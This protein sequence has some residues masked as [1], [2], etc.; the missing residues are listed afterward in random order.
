METWISALASVIQYGLFKFVHA[1]TFILLRFFFFANYR[2]WFNDQKNAKENINWRYTDKPSYQI[3]GQ[4]PFRK[5][6]SRQLSPET[7]LS[8]YWI[9]NKI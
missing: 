2:D 7:L 6:S 3:H 5:L 1:I 9:N 4:K 8:L